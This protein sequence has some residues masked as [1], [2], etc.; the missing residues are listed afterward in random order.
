M[1]GRGLNILVI[2]IL[3]VLFVTFGFLS[4]TSAHTITLTGTIRDFNSSHSDFESAEC[5]HI[6]GLVE[7]N[8]GTDKKP[9]FGPNGYDCVN[10]PQSFAQWYNNVSGVNLSKSYTITLDNGLATSGGIY[11]YDNSSFFPIDNDLFGNE[12]NAHNY[13]FT[14]EIHTVFTYVG[15]ED[16]TFRGD[17]DIWVFIDDELVVDLGGIHEA[18]TG[19][20]NLD[21]LDLIVGNTYDFDLF[22]AERHTVLSNFRI[23]TSIELEPTP[24][25]TT[26]T[27]PDTSTTTTPVSTTTSTATSCQPWE[28][29]CGDVC[30]DSG[31][32][33]CGDFC[34]DW[35]ETCCGDVCCSED[36]L[37]DSFTKCVHEY[38]GCL[39][40][41]IYGEY[42]EEVELLR[43][44]RDE[45]LSQSPVG[46]EII[47]L[48]YQWSPVIVK[49]MEKNEEFKKEVEGMIDGVLE[50][51]AEEAE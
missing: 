39:Y 49:A 8:L 30:C 24:T 23:Q 37:C 46:Q 22:F 34:C 47:E 16:F 14:Y 17:D 27:V 11:T 36:E 45:V 6:T 26:T 43:A 33:C 18:V 31:E 44:F 25:T 38:I 7:T 35:G 5:G 48:Y 3:A 21:S 10:S 51:I 15:G 28:T 9:I 29:E 4:N 1:R 41:E 2:T 19:S 42:S 13:H 32:H 50:L 20:V 12:G 40:H